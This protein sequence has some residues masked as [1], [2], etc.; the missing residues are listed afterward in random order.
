MDVGM[1]V[2]DSTLS[3]G[4]DPLHRGV[5]VTPAGKSDPSIWHSGQYYYHTVLKE[6][7]DLNW[8]SPEVREALSASSRAP[9]AQF[10][11][12]AGRYFG[13]GR[14][15]RSSTAAGGPHAYRV[16]NCDQGIGL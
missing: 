15:K 14:P 3:P 7:P 9:R 12:R 2:S 13:L 5:K 8:H 4:I 11:A 1:S 16:T 6:Q 10:P